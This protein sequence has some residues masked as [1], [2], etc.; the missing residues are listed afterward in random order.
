MALSENIQPDSQLGD[1][2][3]IGFA[4]VISH[5]KEVPAASNDVHIGNIEIN[6]EAGEADA[7]TIADTVLDKLSDQLQWQARMAGA[8]V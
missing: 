3:S 1:I 6:I 2:V 5:M 7:D 4:D 8:R